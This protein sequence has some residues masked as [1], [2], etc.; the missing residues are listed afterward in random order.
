M[1]KDWVGKNKTWQIGIEGLNRI[2]IKF[3][4]NG[5]EIK[6]RNQKNKD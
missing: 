6:L 2:Q 3:V 1:N 5:Q 4:L